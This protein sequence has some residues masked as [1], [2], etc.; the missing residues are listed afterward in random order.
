MKMNKKAQAGMEYL[1][2]YGWAIVLVAAVIGVLVLIVGQP[3]SETGFSSSN[4]TKLLIKG[5]NVE[6]NLAT[7]KLQNVTGGEIKIETVSN[8]SGFY[9]C[10]AVNIA[11]DNT[12]ISGGELEIQCQTIPGA[13]QGKINVKFT[14]ASGLLQNILISGGGTTPMA[15]P[16]EG[17]NTDYLCSDGYNNDSDALID[18]EDP[19]C[20]TLIGCDP[21]HPQ[22]PCPLPVVKYCEF[23]TETTCDD[24]FDNDADEGQP[25]GGIDCIDS[26][27]TSSPMCT[28]SASYTGIQCYPDPWSEHAGA[29]TEEKIT[30]YYQDIYGIE[31]LNIS[32][33]SRMVIS[34]CDAPSPRTYTATVLGSDLAVL[35][36]TGWKI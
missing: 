27:C 32:K 36:S 24:E 19:D 16:P 17:E 23:E 21:N 33:T 26:D 25:G 20:D 22:N 9:D 11:A 8:P 28:A 14:D 12:V 31:I 6:N 30:N 7:I 2:T 10:E 35:T 5:A 29:T 18:C 13:S 34:M 4:P 15:A 3:L 1:I